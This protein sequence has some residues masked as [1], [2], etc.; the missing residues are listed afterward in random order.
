M[1]IKYTYHRATGR[2]AFTKLRSYANK[3]F[4]YCLP[5]G[6]PADGLRLP[7]LLYRLPERISSDPKKPV[8]VAEGEKDC[9]RL[10]LL[11]LVATCNYDGGGRGKWSSSYSR[12]FRDRDVVILADNDWTGQQHLRTW[13]ATYSAS[14]EASASSTWPARRPRATYRTGWT[15]GSVL[16]LLELATT[17][18]KWRARIELARME[19]PDA[20]DWYIR[21]ALEAILSRGDRRSCCSSY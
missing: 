20:A 6:K 13:P 21:D 3:K 7:K 14:R 17:A 15:G 1:P 5:N 19:D 16:E 12:Y 9:D 8:F 4:K 11:E 2:L 18:P 10:Y